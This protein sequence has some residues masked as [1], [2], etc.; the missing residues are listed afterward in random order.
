MFFVIDY[1]QLLHST[2][3]C[4]ESRQQGFESAAK[5]SDEDVPGWHLK[6]GIQH[7]PE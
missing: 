2:A 3:R 1:L 4:A 5:V 6:F 7:E